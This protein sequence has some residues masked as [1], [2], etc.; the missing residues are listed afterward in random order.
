M[1]YNELMS[2][3]IVKGIQRW[4]AKNPH[5]LVV[6]LHVL[7][8]ITATHLYNEARSREIAKLRQQEMDDCKHAAYRKAVTDAHASLIRKKIQAGLFEGMPELQELA[9]ELE[10]LEAMKKLKHANGNGGALNALYFVTINVKPDVTFAELHKQC[11]KFSKRRIVS[12]AEWVYE[13]RGSHELEQGKGM[14]AHMLV[15]QRGDIFDGKF[16]QAVQSTFGKLCGNPKH[17]DIRVCK[18]EWAEDK[19]AYMRGAKTEDGKAE[20]CAID[21]IWRGVNNISP[22][23]THSNNGQAQHDPSE[24]SASQTD[25]E[26]E[27]QPPAHGP[28]DPTTDIVEADVL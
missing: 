19:R 21:A 18:P 12:K 8:L 27:Y 16:R 23:Y 28:I 22:Y 10:K 13:Q 14:H 17:V 5:P 7:E 4:D 2:K 6:G 11:T 24:S 26:D 3:F 15:T 20:K 9:P 1:M 25:T